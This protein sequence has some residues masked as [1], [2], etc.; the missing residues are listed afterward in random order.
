MS[1]SRNFILL[2]LLFLLIVGC[3]KRVKKVEIE[4]FAFGT[5]FKM[6]IY[7][8]NETEAK[9]QL[10]EAFKEIERI[11]NRYNSKKNG[12]LVDIL[13]KDGEV[14]F[15]KEG[16]EI[17]TKVK[18][19]YQLSGKRYDVTIEPLL[20]VWGLSEENSE[21]KSLPID[22]ELKDAQRKVDFSKVE[23]LNDGVIKSKKGVTIDTGSFLKG[24]AIEKAKEKLINLGVKSAFIS[25]VSS[26]TTIGT[27]GDGENWKIGIQNPE[28]QSEV[29]GVVQLNGQSLGVSGDYQNYIEIG[30]KRYHHII[31]KETG[32]P[33]RD[34]KMVAVLCGDSFTADLYST[35]FFLMNEKDVLDFVDKTE[36]LEVMIVK[37]DNKIVKSKN[38]QIKL[39]HK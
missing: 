29:L 6:Y 26:I 25:A 35:A 7:S 14:I 18:E 37:G 3:G 38:F 22:S 12:S 16:I 21:R 32:Y 19:V 20:K 10:E 39:V 36:N 23:I 28:K 4:R 2:F 8:D 34:K 33:V 1:K 15:D 30:G 11:D 24:Y 5:F 31:N 9:K 13:N 17:L 27:K